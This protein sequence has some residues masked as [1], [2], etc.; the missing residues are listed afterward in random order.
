M[1]IKDLKEE[2]AH[3]DDNMKVGGAGHFGEY[4]EC[5]AVW[6]GEVKMKRSSRNGAEKELIFNILLESAGEEPD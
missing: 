2:I 4:L 3:L 6:V 5:L 1:T